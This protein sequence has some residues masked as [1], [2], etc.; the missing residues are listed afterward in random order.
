M[1]QSTQYCSV[2]PAFLSV[3]QVPVLTLHSWRV[4]APELNTVKMGIDGG[5]FYNLEQRKLKVTLWNG[6]CNR[7]YHLPWSRAAVLF[8]QH[9][10]FHHRGWLFFSL[11]LYYHH[12]HHPLLFA[13]CPCCSSSSLRIRD[14]VSVLILIN[15]KIHLTFSLFLWSSFS[16]PISIWTC[17]Q[18]NQWRCKY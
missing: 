1:V 5:V 11:F 16:G 15:Y 6:S 17:S 4:Y 8:Q 9:F 2:D 18:K 7:L 14:K 12:H 13:A 10:S 3:G